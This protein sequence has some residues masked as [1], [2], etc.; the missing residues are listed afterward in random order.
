MKWETL[1]TEPRSQ[2]SREEV[3][4]QSNEEAGPRWFQRLICNGA[5]ECQ[6]NKGR[7]PADRRSDRKGHL[8]GRGKGEGGLPSARFRFQGPLRGASQ[9]IPGSATVGTL[10]RGRE[11]ERKSQDQVSGC[12]G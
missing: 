2:G 9:V 8:R 3:R 7:T 6:G 4:A 10:L 1:Q 5:R 12:P 11:N